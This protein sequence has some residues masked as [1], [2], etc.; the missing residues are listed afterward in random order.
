M[1]TSKPTNHG[2]VYSHIKKKNVELIPE[3]LLSI[4]TASSV[5]SVSL[6]QDQHFMLMLSPSQSSINMFSWGSEL[7]FSRTLQPRNTNNI[8]LNIPEAYLV[9]GWVWRNQLRFLGCIET[10]RW[11]SCMEEEWPSCPH[12]SLNLKQKPTDVSFNAT[13]RPTFYSVLYFYILTI[14]AGH[15]LIVRTLAAEFSPKQKD[16]PTVVWLTGICYFCWA[17]TVMVCD[18]TVWSIQDTETA[19]RTHSS[20]LQLLTCVFRELD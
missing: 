5:F 4:R 11:R 9:S 18:R 10:T 3:T 8:I 19:A 15:N 17:C 16:L 7:H 1:G 6:W 12:T 2:Y 13:N 14:S 20:R